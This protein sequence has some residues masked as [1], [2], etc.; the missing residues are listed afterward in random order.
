MN[1]FPESGKVWINFQGVEGTSIVTKVTALP[2]D[3][4]QLTKP[5]D[6]ES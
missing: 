6:Q 3:L 1:T 5:W 4:Y 2:L